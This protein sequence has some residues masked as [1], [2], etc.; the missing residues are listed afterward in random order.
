MSVSLPSTLEAGAN[1]LPV[2]AL[3]LAIA[4]LAYA[5]VPRA[6]AAISYGIVTVTFLWQAVS[7]LL[8]A[9]TWLADLAPFAHVALVPAQPFRVGSAAVI[10]GAGL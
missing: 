9:P 8:G 2:A 4:G 7:A 10:I 5:I 3:F 6:S 1:C